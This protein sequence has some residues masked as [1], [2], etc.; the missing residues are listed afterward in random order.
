MF[1]LDQIDQEGQTR[2]RTRVVHAHVFDVIFA[3]FKLERVT[4]IGSNQRPGE[5]RLLQVEHQ[6]ALTFRFQLFIQFR[7]LFPGFRRVRHQVFVINQR[8]G[9]HC[10]GISDQLAVIA[11]GVPGERE[12]FVLEG[13][14]RRDFR[15]QAGL[16]ITPET[17][18]RPEDDVRAVTGCRNLR[19][20]LFQLVRVFYGDFDTGVFFEFFTHFGQAV[21]AFVAVN[22]DN[23][24]T[25]FNFGESRCGNHHCCKGGQCENACASLDLHICHPFL[26]MC[27]WIHKV[28]QR[29]SVSLFDI[30]FP[31]SQPLRPTPGLCDLCCINLS[32]ECWRT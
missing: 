23:Q 2:F 12:Q 10:N 14:I 19:E 27:S 11:N 18:M 22:P 21:I 17:V 3:V 29:H 26:V 15:Q 1:V 9:F 31:S 7:D 5:V 4:A 8:Q 24:L 25:F 32:Y 13:F 30:L 28:V 16:C 6:R 20:F